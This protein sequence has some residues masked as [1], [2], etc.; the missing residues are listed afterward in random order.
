MIGMNPS[1]GMNQASLQGEYIANLFGRNLVSGD[2][3][4]ARI[5]ATFDGVGIVRYEFLAHSSTGGGLTGY[6]VYRVLD[7]GVLLVLD[8]ASSPIEHGMVS[9]DG[10]TFSVVDT[11][12][13]DGHIYLMLGIKKQS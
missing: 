11:N 12:P 5:M 13:A 2:Y 3:W 10:N 7:S 8:A 9:S 1:T 4:T 6:M